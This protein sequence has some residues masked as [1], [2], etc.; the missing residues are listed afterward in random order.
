MIK[1]KNI[2]SYNAR[3]IAKFVCLASLLL[4]LIIL[5]A[6]LSS[7]AFGRGNDASYVKVK[8]GGETLEVEIPISDGDYEEVYLFGIDVWQGMDAL[9]GANRIAKAKVSGKTAKARVDIDGQL[10]E[11]LCKGYLFAE[12][13]GEDEY[14]A[15]TGIYYVS[16]PRDVA[17][18]IKSDEDELST[19]LKGATGEV[20]ELTDANASATVITVELGDLMLPAREEGAFSYVWNG[21][22]YYADRAAIEKLDNRIAAYAK[23]GIKVYLELV[24]T[25]A[26]SELPEKISDIVFD[27]PTGKSGYALNMT[28]LEGASRICGMLDLLAERY[29]K[30]GLCDAFIMGRNVNLFSE[31]YAGGPDSE[32]GIKNYLSAVRSAYNILLSHTPHGKVYLAVNNNWNVASAGTYNVRDMLSAFNN[33]ASAEGDFFWQVSIEAN[34]SDASDSSIWEDT[35]ATER[36]EFI[37]PANIETLSNH[38]AAHAYTCRGMQRHILVNR[39]AIGGGNAEEQAAS[40]AYAYYKSMK[41]ECV[42]AIIYGMLVDDSALNNGIYA[43]DA[44]G[45]LTEKKLTEVFLGIDNKN[46]VD[47]SFVSNYVSDWKY[48][49]KSLA[50][51]SVRF[52]N[53]A[54][55]GLKGYANDESFNVVDMSKGDMLG[56]VPLTSGAYSELRYSYA[57]ERP[58]LYVG[59]DRSNNNEM[60]GAVSNDITLDSLKEG[61][62]LEIFA[63]MSASSGSGKLTVRLMGFDKNGSECVYRASVDIGA[64]EWNHYYFDVSDFVKKV[65]EETVSLSVAVE[66]TDPS[67]EIRG[68]WLSE[69]NAV[70]EKNSSLGV[71]FAILGI[72]AAAGGITA[73]VFWFKKNYVFV[74]E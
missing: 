39:L 20:K 66:S 72:V 64:N 12:K 11:T 56:F 65:D 63:M 54:G 29:G 45:N 61:E 52:E 25:K 30:S 7:C 40:Y 4:V 23:S 27:A 35:L 48:L 14:R 6:A 71:I 59:A 9:N 24:Q 38:L 2:K 47:L 55:E 5:S 51:Q 46:K 10:A 28:T 70:S 16:N 37:S 69:I 50:K 3:N 26:A 68:F 32:A 57:L 58:A 31:Y 62:V 1:N 36:S 21:L 74:K 41:T 17:E 49:Y 13:T 73:F 22:T 34:S 15:I 42:D 53:V 60:F 67:N 43:A 8:S 18:K 19:L 33:L 44:M